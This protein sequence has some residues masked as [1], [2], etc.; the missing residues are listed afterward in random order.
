M[1]PST[2]STTVCRLAV[3]TALIRLPC[4]HP[5]KCVPVPILRDPSTFFGQQHMISRRREDS[6]VS[7]VACLVLSEQSVSASF[8]KREDGASYKRG[9]DF[10]PSTLFHA[11][12]ALLRFREQVYCLDCM[13]F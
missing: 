4:K 3:A 11:D 2:V 5:S 8:S 6:N 13:P 12:S 9:E 1:S 10:N 7:W